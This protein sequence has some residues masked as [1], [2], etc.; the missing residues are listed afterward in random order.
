MHL[1]R[2]LDAGAPGG[3]RRVALL[4]GHRRLAGEVGGAG[5][6]GVAVHAA[7]RLAVAGGAQVDH[8]QP[9]VQLV[10]EHADRRAAG[11]E[12]VQHLPGDR[13]RI[14][15]NALLD[16]PVVAGEHGDPRLL[17]VRALAALQ[18]GEV[19]GQLLEAAQ[20]TGRLGQPRLA[21]FGLLPRHV[22]GRLAGR[23]PPVFAH[24]DSPFRTMGSPA[25]QKVTRCA[26]SASA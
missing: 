19:D 6:E 11:D 15:G 9:C 10:G 7:Q 26:R 20:R 17:Q 4:G 24:R 16:H 1:A 2:A 13:L 5:A 25:T 14:G 3:Q 12:V 22:V 23:L 21:L 18:R 8:L